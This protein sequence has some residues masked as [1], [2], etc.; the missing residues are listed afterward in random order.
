MSAD[1]THP[2]S[3][4]APTDWA[5]I[6]RARETKRDHEGAVAA[7]RKA[8]RLNRR[9]GD[10]WFGLGRALKSLGRLDGAIV[11]LGNAVSLGPDDATRRYLLAHV[12]AAKGRWRAAARRFTEAVCLAPGY[13][14]AHFNLGICCEQSG[15]LARAER[16]VAI[17]AAFN[18]GHW[19]AQITLGKLRQSLDRW[20]EA[21]APLAAAIRLKPADWNGHFALGFSRGHRLGWR[22]DGWPLARAVLCRTKDGQ[23][24]AVDFVEAPEAGD[25]GAVGADCSILIPFGKDMPERVENIETVIEYIARTLPGTAVHVREIGAARHVSEYPGLRYRREEPADG[26]FVRT[27]LCNRMAHEAVTPV[28]VLYDADVLVPPEQ[29]LTA[30]ALAGDGAADLILAYDGRCIDL[31]RAAIP[32][33]RAGAPIETWPRHWH[34]IRPYSIGGVCVWN[35]ASFMASGMENEAFENWGQEDAERLQRTLKLGLR[36]ARVEGPI[37]HLNHP[38]RGGA[39]DPAVAQ[40]KATA[41]EKLQAMSQEALRTHIAAW[42]WV[43]QPETTGA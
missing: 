40:A 4:T 33:I 43:A 41:L 19:E 30:I 38:R 15:E 17:A 31:D 26:R 32:E 21:E 28:I 27:K 34:S 12:L 3:E 20:E 6:G 35:R 22:R 37:Y 36:V 7:Y 23:G 1:A 42:P 5:G 18:P 16:A 13:W 9:D 24:M 8:L 25:S 11:A 14:A 2:Q 10:A 39:T 29:M